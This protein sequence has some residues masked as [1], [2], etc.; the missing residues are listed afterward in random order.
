MK[1]IIAASVVVSTAFLTA[2]GVPS[3][4]DLANDPELLMEAVAECTARSFQGE[5]TSEDELCVNAGKAMRN[6]GVNLK[7]M[8]R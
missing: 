3:A 8:L 6:G 1:K 4:E 2:C 7:S 5:D